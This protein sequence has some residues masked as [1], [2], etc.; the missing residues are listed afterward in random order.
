[1]SQVSAVTPA[2]KLY[3]LTNDDEFAVLFPKLEAALATGL[4]ALLQIRRK[5]TLQ[6]ANGTSKLYDEAR[7]IVRLAKTHNVPV[8]MNDDTELA[9]KLRIGVHLG[10]QDGQIDDAK[11]HLA[12]NQIIGRTC[13]G[14]VSLVKRAKNAGASYAA[15]G[16]V[17][18]STTKP[19]AHVIS[20]QQLIEGCQQGIDI[21]V[22]G[23]LTAENIAQ[24]AGLP[25]T[26]VAVVGDIMDLPVH[27]IVE[28]CQQW[29]QAL[30]K[31]QAPA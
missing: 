17:F 30:S 2:P 16:A 13:H 8:V 12:S 27:Q 15:M 6:S 18:A 7:Q 1:M 19:S 23:G 26:Y 29:Q 31:W 21:C 3:L 4:I 20:R 22:I 5:K 11:R 14:D 9:K 25:I 24:L 28:R 10:Q